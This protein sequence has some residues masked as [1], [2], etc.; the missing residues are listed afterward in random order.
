VSDSEAMLRRP[1]WR[2]LGTVGYLLFDIAVLWACLRAVGAKPPLLAVVVGYQVGYLANLIPIP[3]GV[4]VL[5]GGLLG[6]LLLYGLPVAPTAAAVVLYHAIALWVPAL[7]GTIG[8]ARLRRA[9][10]ARA[11]LR[12]GETRDP[13]LARTAVR[14]G[15]AGWRDGQRELRSRHAARHARHSPARGRARGGGRRWRLHACCSGNGSD[16]ARMSWRSAGPG[17]WLRRARRSAD[18]ALA[19]SEE[20]RPDVALVAGR[21]SGSLM[22]PSAR[23]R[24]WWSRWCSP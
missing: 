12:L 16:N 17:W 8:F 4:G 22:S 6:A 1:D 14:P 5:E 3:A 2:L 21:P 15:P 9:V 18:R 24:P 7:G 10:T 20:A 13:G 23:R 19:D 11:P